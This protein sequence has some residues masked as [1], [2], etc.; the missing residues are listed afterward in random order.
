MKYYRILQ[1]AA[2]GIGLAIMAHG[3]VADAD[4][5]NVLFI[6]VDDLRP[7]LNCYGQKQIISPN[8]D[9][10]AADGLLFEHAYC[11]LAVC[12]PSR[13]S[14]LTGMRPDTCKVWT[15]GPH[16]RQ[17]VPDVVTLPQ[18]FKNHGYRTQAL[19]KIFHGSFK[20]AGAGSRLDD[21][22]SWSIPTWYGSPQYYFSPEGMKIARDV[23][24]EKG[25]NGNSP[26]ALLDPDDW[27]DYFV[28]GLPDEAPDVP[29]DVPYDGQLAEH[30]IAALRELN[31]PSSGI[32]KPFF[33][34]VGFI[35]TH[36]PFVAPKKYWDL[37]QRDDIRLAD[38]PFPP[39]GA[40]K[41]A[42]TNWE[43]MR[44][45]TGIPQK[46]PVADGQA[47]ELIHGYRACV[48]YTDALIGSII[49]ELDRLG[50]REKTIIVLWGDH[51]WKLG[52]HG[53]WC[54][55]TNFEWDTRVPMI[56]S[57][58]TFP[59]GL[60]TQAL[61]EFV[62]IYPSLC[63]LCELPLPAHLEGS[64]FVP[65]MKQPDLPWKKAAFSQYPRGKCMG[66]SM[67]TE[68]WRY[69]RW[70][71]RTGGK[72]VAVELYDHDKD[73]G[74]NVNVAGSPENA[75]VVRK[76]SAQLDAGWKGARPNQQREW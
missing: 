67:R 19:G 73:P 72:V 69:T 57:A 42:L 49:D 8:I 35:S 53:M 52:E 7:E 28:R 15:I 33:L 39:E 4:R 26:A 74:E 2:V 11:Q 38:N 5:L 30:A 17:F 70:Q 62:D 16:F 56:I 22:L 55:H 9:K 68:R 58:P 47:R 13:T 1:V 51:G 34:G 63:E 54:K 37:Y 27:I 66:Y 24:Q 61:S 43:E 65:L 48:S 23:F 60:R 18:H 21:P 29:D 64:S 46:G 45:Y 44:I 75:D 41:L 36:L 12:A 76:L 25:P 50:L 3:A 59:G 40:P 20:T 32:K 31:A 6:A 71:E 10:L 14:L